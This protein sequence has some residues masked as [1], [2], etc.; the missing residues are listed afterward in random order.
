MPADFDRRSFR[1]QRTDFAAICDHIDAACVNL[2]HGSSQRITLIV[3]ELFI[4]SITHGYGGDSGEPVWITI[5]HDDDQCHLIYEDRAPGYN[6]FAAN[7]AA[8]HDGD[9]D[10]RPVG[11]LGIFLAIRLSSVHEYRRDADRNV[12][13]LVIPLASRN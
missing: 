13:E 1:A 9:V 2:T 5:S 6:P 12:I 10:Q 8:V 4:N 11:N 3:E 7:D